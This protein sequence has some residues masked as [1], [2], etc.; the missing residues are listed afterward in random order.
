MLTERFFFNKQTNNIFY[1]QLIEI[2]FIWK[3]IQ[4]N[5]TGKKI[6][7]QHENKVESSDNKITTFKNN[8]LYLTQCFSVEFKKNTLIT[9]TLDVKL[10]TALTIGFLHSKNIKASSSYVKKQESQL[11]INKLVHAATF[12]N[13]CQEDPELTVNFGAQF[14]QINTCLTFDLLFSEISSSVLEIAD[15]KVYF[16][17]ISLKDGSLMQVAAEPDTK[18]VLLNATNGTT[19]LFGELSSVNE[20]DF[21]NSIW[22]FYLVAN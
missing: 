4:N 10:M 14:D 22:K 8:N 5:E 11:A 17:V 13:Y 9:N 2:G 20:I 21:A 15:S 7:I 12:S 3:H 6:I 18:A 1:K 16:N 19:L